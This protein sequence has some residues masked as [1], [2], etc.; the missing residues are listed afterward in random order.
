ML[1]DFQKIRH[2]ELPQLNENNETEAR[3]LSVF[4]QLSPILI[5]AKLIKQTIKYGNL[6]KKFFFDKINESFFLTSFYLFSDLKYV[7]FF[8]QSYRQH[9]RKDYKKNL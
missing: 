3:F 1:K 7:D 9:L 2:V 6:S 5:A 8:N 4:F